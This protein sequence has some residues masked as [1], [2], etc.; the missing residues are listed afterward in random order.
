MKSK[1][2]RNRITRTKTSIDSLLEKNFLREGEIE[3]ERERQRGRER[4]RERETKRDK[5]ITQKAIY[6]KHDLR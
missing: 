3:G 1:I 5:K 4:G 6:E 2:L